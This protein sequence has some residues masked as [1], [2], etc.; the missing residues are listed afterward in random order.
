MCCLQLH[1]PE[2]GVSWNPVSDSS[3]PPYALRFLPD[4]AANLDPKPSPFSRVVFFWEFLDC[5]FSSNLKTIENGG[6]IHPSSSSLFLSCPLLSFK[7]VALG[8]L[9]DQ[10]GKISC[11]LQPN[12]TT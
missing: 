4:S 2:H 7:L 6:E 1:T 3:D 12:L 9:D 5:V 10:Q 8:W 11:I